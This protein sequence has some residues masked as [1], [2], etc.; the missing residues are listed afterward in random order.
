M[1]EAVQRVLNEHGLTRRGQRAR[2]GLSHVTIGQMIDGFPVQMD[3]VVA[4]ARGFG[5]DVNEWLQMA[6][7]DPIVAQKSGSEI[8]VEGIKALQAEFGKPVPVWFH[9]D[10]KADLTPDAARA[11]LDDL[12]A[13][14]AEEAEAIMAT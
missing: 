14:M 3:S 8:L 9:E 2:T 12:R 10:T 4:F 6:G 5:L 1:G 11:I 13:Q 7:Y